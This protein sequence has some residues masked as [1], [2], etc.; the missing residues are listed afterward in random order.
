[1]LTPFP[2]RCDN[3]DEVRRY[4]VPFALYELGAMLKGDAGKDMLK[5][6]RSYSHD[7]NFKLRLHVRVHLMLDNMRRARVAAT[8]AK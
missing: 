5:R 3:C 7:F 1:M 8:D 6:A 4:T 2:G